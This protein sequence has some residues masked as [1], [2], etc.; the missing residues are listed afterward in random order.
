MNNLSGKQLVVGVTGGI[1]AYKA[2][3]L[4][5]LFKQAGAE[6]RVVMTD[7]A[8]EFVTPLTLQT[9]S[10][11]KVH[12]H[13]LDEE[14]EQSLG[15]IEL[16]RWADAILV[17]PASA[18]FIA[19]LAQGRADNLLAAVCL[20]TDAPVAVAPAMNRQMW[21][22]AMTRRNIN[23][24]E[25]NRIHRFG[26]GIGEQ[27]CGEIGEGRML[28]PAELVEKTSALF[29]SGKLAGRKVIVTAGPTWEAI[30]PVRGLSNR[31]S[32]KMGY[33]IA[34]AARE[35]G[36]HVVLISGPTCLADPERLTTVRIESAEQMLQ[37][38]KHHCSDADIFIA[39]AAVSDY[40]PASRSAI[41][42]G[43]QDLANPMTLERNPDVVATIAEQNP[44]LFCVGFAAET[45]D[46]A[47]HAKQK[48]ADKH[49][50]LIAANDI[51]QAG[52]GMNADQ[53][54]LTLIDEHGSIELSLQPKTRLAREL[55]NEIAER[56][57]AKNT[58]EN[59][60]RANR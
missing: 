42:L 31:S 40:R 37:Q 15:H 46:L 9:L 38:A 49:L 29:A 18:N 54:A 34:I 50:D 55:I 48:L 26:P 33:A 19:M 12:R 52:Q 4:V 7:A 36:A 57:N 14:A 8:V 2:A 17:A 39:A 3:E 56:Y 35:A 45:H 59:S 24:I 30:D 43:K 60:R 53:N 13:L 47:E 27:A 23:T 16:A 11:H 1:A 20:A 10:G 51:S 28:E 5:R 21:D 25:Q 58:T 6:V 22:N 44:E 41:K 32:G